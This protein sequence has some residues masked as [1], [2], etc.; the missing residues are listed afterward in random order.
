MAV[1]DRAKAAERPPI[2][3]SAVA[4]L[5]PSGIPEPRFG[6]F[7]RLQSTCTTGRV[8]TSVPE[9]KPGTTAMVSSVWPLGDGL[10]QGASLSQRSKGSWSGCGRASTVRR[11]PRLQRTPRRFYPPFAASDHGRCVSGSRASSKKLCF[12]T[13]RQQFSTVQ[14]VVAAGGS[15]PVEMSQFVAAV[16]NESVVD[17]LARVN[18]P[19]Q[20]VGKLL[21]APE[22]PLP[23]PG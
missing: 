8:L 5:G 14:C 15:V 17:V 3:L 13:L 22:T 16:P 10:S 21:P 12:V 18:L 19:D 2:P 6:D 20:P 9:L 23:P 1:A 4:N 7:I 11:R